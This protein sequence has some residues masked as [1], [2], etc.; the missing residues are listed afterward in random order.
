MSR[1]PVFEEHEEHEV[2]STEGTEYSQQKELPSEAQMVLLCL[3]YLRDLRRA[4]S[5]KDGLLMAEGLD[6]C[7]Q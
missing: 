7:T 2:W 6:A 1:R 3:D 5:S 4:Y